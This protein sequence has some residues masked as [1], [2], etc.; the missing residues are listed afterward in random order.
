M[1]LPITQVGNM[2]GTAAQTDK[3]KALYLEQ[4]LSRVDQLG[5]LP[6]VIWKVLEITSSGD[7]S[8]AAMERAIKVDPGLSSKI[9]ILANSA[10]FGLPRRVSTVREAIMFLGFR[11]VR[12]MAM[13]VATFD[14]FVGKTDRGSLRRRGWWRHSI[15]T[16]V[17]CRWLAGK[18]PDLVPD[19]AY[20]VGL[21]HL[22]GKNLLDR[23]AI[24]DYDNVIQLVDKGMA[25]VKAEDE[26]YKVNHI[27][28]M[29]EAAKQ[30]HL[31]EN[32]CFALNYVQKPTT[33]DSESRLRACVAVGSRF[34]F[35]A[36]HGHVETARHIPA[37]AL[38]QMTLSHRNM[39]GLIEEAGSQIVAAQ[40]PF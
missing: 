18:S 10:A 14:M 13:T 33:K 36:K 4:L 8:A 11:T 22:L 27:D 7:G 24:G 34:A 15:D 28:I 16:A 3:V 2:A 29:V 35:L 12:S 9:L 17:C 32:I 26:V 39:A 38:D 19:E 37:W 31:P 25:D 1:M 20:T 40:M 5:V 21:V 23:F 6:H 30:W